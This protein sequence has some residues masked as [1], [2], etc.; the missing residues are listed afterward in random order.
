MQSLRRAQPADA[1]AIAALTRRAYAKW[2]PLIGREPLPMRADYAVAVASHRF[3]L[4]YV[5]ETL[6]ALI[7]TTPR[8]DALLIV[9]VAVDPAFQG[10]GHGRRL[11]ALAEDLAAEAGLAIMRLY[12]N[13]AFAENVRLYQSVGYAIEREETSE[14]GVTTYMAKTL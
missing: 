5:G 9:N 13:Q 10:R 4:L 3:D 2:V 6:A 14:L 1:S 12:T 7:E 8:D 11:L